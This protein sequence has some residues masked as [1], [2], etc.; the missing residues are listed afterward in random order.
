MYLLGS[1]LRHHGINYHTYVDDTQLYIYFDL[2]DPSVAIDKVNKCSS[3][4]K[5]WT[6]QN[7]LKINHCKTEFLYYCVICMCFEVLYLS[8]LKVIFNG[9]MEIYFRLVSSNV[10]VVYLHVS[11]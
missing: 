8:Y 7:K 4:F 3:D 5:I 2:S 11:L 1:I 9:I 10:V 6:I